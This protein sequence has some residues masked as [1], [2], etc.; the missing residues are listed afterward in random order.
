MTA[1]LRSNPYSSPSTTPDHGVATQDPG[2]VAFLN[3]ELSLEQQ[4]AY[5]P[6]INGIPQQ[7]KIDLLKVYLNNLEN[8]VDGGSVAPAL[9]QNSDASLHTVPHLHTPSGDDYEE[10]DDDEYAED[11]DE[12]A[13]GEF[14]VIETIQRKGSN[15]SSSVVKSPR[16]SKHTGKSKN[17]HRVFKCPSDGCKANFPT[18]KGLT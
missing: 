15:L 9:L 8:T 6:L 4:N 10:D 18:R 7:A 16:V 5:F 3:H 11:E 17:V 1:P 13:E 2:I 14:E 12:D